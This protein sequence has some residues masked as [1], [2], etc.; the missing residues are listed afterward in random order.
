[1]VAFERNITAQLVH[2]VAILFH[3]HL[4]C[5]SLDAHIVYLYSRFGL[6]SVNKQIHV[7]LC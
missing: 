3:L 5:A 1:M 6:N 4:H 2:S 7:I